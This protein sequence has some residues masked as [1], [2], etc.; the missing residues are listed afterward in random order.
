MVKAM[1][2]LKLVVVHKGFPLRT[3]DPLRYPIEIISLP[4]DERE[5]H[6]WTHRADCP[7]PCGWRGQ[8]LR[9]VTGNLLFGTALF[10]A[11]DPCDQFL[12]VS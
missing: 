7:Q 2:P 12:P 11:I 5:I 4:A 3:A 1:T 10:G 8:R 9:V 6:F